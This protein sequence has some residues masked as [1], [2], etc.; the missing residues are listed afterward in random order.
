MQEKAHET[1]EGNESPSSALKP[2][3]QVSD[4]SEMKKNGCLS[5]PLQFIPPQDMTITAAVA[6]Y[7]EGCIV[8]VDRGGIQDLV[9]EGGLSNQCRVGYQ[10]DGREVTCAGAGN[11]IRILRVVDGDVQQHNLKVCC[12]DP[13]IDLSD[14][15]C[16]IPEGLVVVRIR[17]GI[18]YVFLDGIFCVEIIDRLDGVLGDG[19]HMTQQ[20]HESRQEITSSDILKPTGSSLAIRARNMKRRYS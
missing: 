17:L 15:I 5:T 12:S 2:F 9:V 13:E 10:S 1:M 11:G 16:R 3:T 19:L 8:G 6:T 7:L 20:E 4:D 18:P 14:G